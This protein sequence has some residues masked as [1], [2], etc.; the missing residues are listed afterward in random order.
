M[1]LGEEVRR[2]HDDDDDECASGLVVCI[3]LTSPDAISVCQ[4]RSH[5]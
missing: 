4:F 3:S 5:F 1:G 2:A